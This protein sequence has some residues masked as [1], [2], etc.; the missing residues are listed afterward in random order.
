MLRTALQA[1]ENGGVNGSFL[2][3]SQRLQYAQSGRFF[4]LKLKRSAAT[5]C[6]FETLQ[7]G[8]FS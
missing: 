5:K 4:T 2:L 7:Q 8:L 6:E 3:T 1:A